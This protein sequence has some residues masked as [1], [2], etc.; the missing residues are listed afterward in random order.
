MN[1]QASSGKRCWLW[2]W[3][4]L[5]FAIASC[6]YTWC[7]DY[8]DAFLLCDF[9]CYLLLY[10][11]ALSDAYPII[12]IAIPWSFTPF[13]IKDIRAPRKQEHSCVRFSAFL[14]FISLSSIRSSSS[15]FSWKK[16]VLQ[17]PI[18]P[19]R[20]PPSEQFLY[21][22]V[23]LKLL[24][25]E[26][27]LYKVNALFKEPCCTEFIWIKGCESMQKQPSEPIAIAESMVKEIRLIIINRMKSAKSFPII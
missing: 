3:Y 15:P 2:A 4:S 18:P 5:P 23:P 7:N 1:L 20:Y 26:I 6:F 11:I 24:V 25:T 9:L 17:N 16:A 8:P 22:K 27:R 12:W 14:P 13:P 10:V 21:G 19:C